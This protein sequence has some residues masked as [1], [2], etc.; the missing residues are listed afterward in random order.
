MKEKLKR[1]ALTVI[2]I[3]VILFMIMIYSFPALTGL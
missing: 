1:W 3:L 2:I